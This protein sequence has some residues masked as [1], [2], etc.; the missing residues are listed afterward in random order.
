MLFDS[1]WRSYFVEDVWS[2]IA[3]YRAAG[4]MAANIWFAALLPE[5]L[6]QLMRV[7]NPTAMQYACCSRA[8]VLVSTGIAANQTLVPSSGL[9]PSSE[10]QETLCCASLQT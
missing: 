4:I 10:S 8:H 6:R 9:V 1:S 5:F 7:S 2:G 3:G